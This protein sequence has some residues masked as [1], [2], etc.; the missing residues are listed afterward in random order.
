MSKHSGPLH[1]ECST[2]NRPPK[3]Q[4]RASSGFIFHLWPRRRTRPA[5]MRRL[6]WWS[7]TAFANRVR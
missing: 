5:L 7:F 3:Q 4:N 6:F 1:S 2:A